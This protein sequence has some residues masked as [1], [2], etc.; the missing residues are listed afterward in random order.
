MADRSS[1]EVSD[2]DKGNAKWTLFSFKLFFSPDV[3]QGSDFERVKK[4]QKKKTL[5]N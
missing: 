1:G 4:A 5:K 3:R 2:A